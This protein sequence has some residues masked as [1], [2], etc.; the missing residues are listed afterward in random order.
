MLT[1]EEQNFISHCSG[2]DVLF[3]PQKLNVTFYPYGVPQRFEIPKPD[4]IQQFINQ[5]EN[6]AY[7]RYGGEER[8]ILKV[9]EKFIGEYNDY[10]SQQPTFGWFN[11]GRESR[12]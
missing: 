10:L 4:N 6:I 12:T 5:L 1:Y 7:S 3:S 8:A 2:F 11:P 9:I